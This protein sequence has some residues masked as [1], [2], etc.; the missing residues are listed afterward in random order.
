MNW[1]EKKSN[2]FEIKVDSI[3][4]NIRIGDALLMMDKGD[5]VQFIV[6]RSKFIVGNFNDRTYI[7]WPDKKS[8]WF[9]FWLTLYMKIWA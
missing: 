4:Q 1:I 6:V 5:Y 2:C 9:N 3:V 7:L 8:K